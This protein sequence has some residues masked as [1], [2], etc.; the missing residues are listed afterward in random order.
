MSTSQG[1][2][3]TRFIDLLS[4]FLHR[5][6][7]VFLVI[8]ALL[9]VAVIA[10]FVYSELQSAARQKAALWAE[11]AQ[12][13]YQKWLDEP[14]L[15]KKQATEKDLNDLLQR[16]LARYPRQYG[17]QRAQLIKAGMAYQLKE[18]INVFKKHYIRQTLEMNRWNQ[19]K[20]ARILGIQ[21]TYLSRLIKELEISH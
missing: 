6:R 16:I 21:R 13:L 18:A 1:E 8:L 2:A 3:K 12:D 14:D 9:L 4:G 20:T 17:A 19:T 7:I 5:F 10:Y 15:T 11:N